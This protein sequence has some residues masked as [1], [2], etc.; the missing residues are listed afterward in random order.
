VDADRLY[1]ALAG[2][3]AVADV[4]SLTVH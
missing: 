3:E 2:L 4:R 1:R